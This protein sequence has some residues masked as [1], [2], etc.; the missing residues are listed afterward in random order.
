[1][2]Y[3]TDVRLAKFRKPTK[4]ISGVTP[5]AVMTVPRACPHGAC[6]YCPSLNAPQSYTPASPAVLR[7]SMMRYDA[8]KQ[9]KCRLKAYQ[10][11]K[12]PSDKIELIIMGGTFF[13]YPLEYQYNFVKRCYDALNEKDSKTLEGAKKLNE[14]TGHRCVA[15]CIETRPD[16]C[17][18]K[19]IKRMLDFG[20]TRVEIGVQVLDDNIYRKINR[21]HTVKDVIDATK[22]LK[23]AG[24]K[25][26]YHLMPGLPG[27]TP[28]KDLKLF[29]KLFSDSRFKPDQIKIYPT[30]VICGSKLVKDFEKKKYRPYSEKK[31]IELLIKMKMKVPEYCRIMRIMREIPPQYLVAGTTRIDLRKVVNNAMA[32]KGVKCNCIRCREI[33]FVQ[34]D[35]P[36]KLID[37]N[38]FL[39]RIDYD[40]SGGR[41]L[42]IQV[43]N[44]ENVIFGL[45]RLRVVGKT[46]FVRELHV[47]GPSLSLGKKAFG[48]KEFQHKGLGVN[49][50]EEAEKTAR[51]EKCSE[52]KVI[53]GVGVREYYRKLGYNLENEYMVKKI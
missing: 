24:F 51:K 8:F 1:M 4:T 23:D 21:G 42:F 28:S 34:R 9:V 25:V 31:L 38:I 10:M 7:A 11:M 35:N 30:Q 2:S 37:K 26:G 29:A 16:F 15:L 3:I 19:E 52:I 13:S 44:K 45:M 22:R 49:L 14:T 43:V 5:I 39:K 12:H 27:M 53:S 32:R 6:T 48:N 20:C 40:A 47:F 33:G 50:M 36:R 17:S 41:E 46:L 18:N